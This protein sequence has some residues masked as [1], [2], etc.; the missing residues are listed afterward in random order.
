MEDLE[1][2]QKYIRKFCDDRD[3][4]HFHNLKGLLISLSLEA[5]EA[6]EH[7][8][9][10]NNLEFK[11]LVANNKELGEEL[12]DVLYW[13]LLTA[14][15][16]GIDLFNAFSENMKQDEAKYPIKLSR[17]SHKKYDKLT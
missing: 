7:V 17:G 3:W 11:E 6:L 9:R 1:K 8:Q 2:L 4:D 10:K 14:D 16:A 12:A 5:S 13:I 15:K